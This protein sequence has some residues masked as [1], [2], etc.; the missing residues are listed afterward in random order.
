MSPEAENAVASAS[1]R[2]L[3]LLIEYDGAGFAGS[4]LQNNALTV[5]GVLEEAIL[6]ATGE[7]SRVA[8]AGR[9]DAG[10]HARGQVASLLTASTLDAETL[11]RAL[12]A[13]LPEDVTIREVA[14][15]GQDFDP[16][17][18]A[19][20]RHYQYAIDNSGARP[21][22]E[23]GRAWH[24][25]GVLDVASMSEAAR[26]MTGR[27]DFAAFASRLGDASA[28]TIRELYCFSVVRLGSSISLDLEA[29]AFLP[30]QVRRMTGA[31][32]EV[33]RSKLSPE[34]YVA[35]LEEAPASVGPAAPPQGLYLMRV[36][37]DRPLFNS[38]P[39]AGGHPWTRA[40]D[41][42][43]TLDSEGGVC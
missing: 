41:R 20:R 6:K 33:G 1:G 40:K 26:G 12:N 15:V 23:R 18:D 31:L 28:S 4:Q 13:R 2:R 14:E 35:L 16:R 37:Y 19:R 39:E 38:A 17:R 27:R 29:N 24:L 36:S 34:Q 11:Q 22:L 5:Q 8:F 42:Q 32:V 10:V 3:A 21:A 25:P 9:T 7:A 43:S 30:H